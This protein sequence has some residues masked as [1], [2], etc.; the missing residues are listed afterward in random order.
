VQR[1]IL[2]AEDESFVQDQKTEKF[3]GRAAY[4]LRRTTGEEGE[5]GTVTEGRKRGKDQK[6]IPNTTS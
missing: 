5:W 4:Y 6:K 1:G 2:G 3:F